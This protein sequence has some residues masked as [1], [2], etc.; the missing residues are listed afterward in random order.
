VRLELETASGRLNILDEEI[1]GHSL[2]IRPSH[3]PCKK[4]GF[5]HPRFIFHV[6]FEVADRRWREMRTYGASA[7]VGST[8]S[9]WEERRACTHGHTSM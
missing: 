5:V 7:Y 4:Q 6:A 2:A 8:E 1:A 9:E 3:V